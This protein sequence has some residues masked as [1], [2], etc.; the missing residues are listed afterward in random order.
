MG[1]TSDDELNV[2]ALKYLFNQSAQGIAGVNIFPMQATIFDLGDSFG[3]TVD[4]NISGPDYER[5]GPLR[6]CTR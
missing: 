4:V 2:A 6:A 1:A 3:S 5:C